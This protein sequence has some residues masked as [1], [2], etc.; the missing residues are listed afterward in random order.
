MLYTLDD[1]SIAVRR[2]PLVRN[3]CIAAS[4]ALILRRL[5]IIDFLC[6]QLTV[7]IEVSSKDD[8]FVW[9]KHWLDSQFARCRV[10]HISAEVS[11][12]VW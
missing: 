7:S 12:V 3:L 10:R 5:G 2:S 1:V 9:V 4:T 6:D 8:A 11:L